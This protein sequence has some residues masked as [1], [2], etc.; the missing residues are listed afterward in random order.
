MGRPSKKRPKKP[1][2]IQKGGRK[3]AAEQHKAGQVLAANLKRQIA[4]GELCPGQKLMSQRALACE[5]GISRASVREVI[6]ELSLQ[7]LLQ[8][9]PSG[10][11]Y[12][13]NLLSASFPPTLDSVKLQSQVMEM[14]AVL[15]GEAAFYA[16]LRATDAQLEKVEEEFVA[17]QQRAD[18]HTT[19]ARAKADLHF[20]MMIAQASHNLLVVSFSQILYS[21][22][23]QAIYA[24]LDRTLKKFGRYP[25]GINAQHRQ[26]FQAL[27][28]RDAE[29]ARCAARD[30]VLFTRQKLEEL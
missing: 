10:G 22:Y 8:V 20:H 23:F 28:S 6:Q 21:R 25:D 14:R 4:A 13:T 26:I 29:S 12:C 16:A 18:L 9:Q 19:L 7:G 5:Y 27:K 15:E 11:T 2:E 17:M 24:V 30:H 1:P 3:L